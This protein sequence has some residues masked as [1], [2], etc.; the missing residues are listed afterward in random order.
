MLLQRKHLANAEVRLWSCRS[1][2]QLE[3]SHSILLP[4]LEEPKINLDF[5]LYVVSSQPGT[6]AYMFQRIKLV[7]KTYHFQTEIAW[8]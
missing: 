7:D 6:T 4:A 5:W 1:I 8:M 3:M 2:L